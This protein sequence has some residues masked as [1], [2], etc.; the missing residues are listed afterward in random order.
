MSIDQSYIK[1]KVIAQGKLQPLDIIAFKP[2]NLLGKAIVSVTGGSYCHIAGVLFCQE[3]DPDNIIHWLLEAESS[4][5]IPGTLKEL[6]AQGKPQDFD[7]WRLPGL[8]PAEVK[9]GL[10]CAEN[11]QYTPYDFGGTAHF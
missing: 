6:W 2:A 8:T 3:I 4:G 11:L 10:D 5:F 1:R 9:L 7:V